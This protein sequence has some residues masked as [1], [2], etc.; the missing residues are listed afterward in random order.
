MVAHKQIW[1]DKENFNTTYNNT[2][3]LPLNINT[4]NLSHSCYTELTE[5]LIFLNVWGLEMDR[6]CFHYLIHCL[7]CLCLEDCLVTPVARG[8]II[9]LY[10]SIVP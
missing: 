1:W 10:S 2:T 7:D 6:R 8:I 4:I 5:S 3:S 9:E